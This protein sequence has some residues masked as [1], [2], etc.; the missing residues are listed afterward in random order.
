MDNRSRTQERISIIINTSSLISAVFISVIPLL[1]L[2]STTCMINLKEIQ[3]PAFWDF[4][5]SDMHIIT[6]ILD[7]DKTRPHNVDF[8]PQIRGEA[9]LVA[10]TREVDSFKGDVKLLQCSADFRGYGI[11][12]GY[13]VDGMAH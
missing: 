4:T 5:S 1:A 2:I 9:K 11:S 12:Q 8:G 13:V 3:G 10:F 6:R 7:F